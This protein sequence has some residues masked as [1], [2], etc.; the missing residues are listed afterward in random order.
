M[1]YIP[2]NQIVTNLYTEG[3]EFVIKSTKTPYQGAYWKKSDGTFYTGKNPNEIP[4]IEIIL[5]TKTI[6]TP[7][8]GSITTI[9]VGGSNI[10][11]AYVLDDL[12]SLPT[13]LKYS[14][15][16]NAPLEVLLNTPQ[17]VTVPPTENDYKLGSYTRYMLTKINDS[18][19]LEVTKTTYDKIVSHDAVWTW[20]LYTPFTIPWTLIGDEDYVYNT[21]G[22]IVALTEERLG[23]YGLQSYFGNDYTQFYKKS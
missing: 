10:P 7:S 6:S 3:N 14:Q 11:P 1:A 13:G 16:T 5:A 19:F 12:I 23:K 17:L 20:E 4:S 8:E 2:K 15:L 22:K 9:T 18:T 21:N